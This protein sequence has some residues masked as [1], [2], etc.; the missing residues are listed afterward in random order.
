MLA[1]VV[2]EGGCTQLTE[3]PFV[4]ET[5]CLQRETIMIEL[6][7]GLPDNVLALRGIGEVTADDYKGVLV[8]AVEEKLD[9]HKKI[10]LLYVLGDDFKRYSAGAAWEDAKVGMKHFTSWD[11]VAVVTDVDWIE[12]AVK[13]VAFAMPCEVR[14]FDDDEL[15]EA[16]QWISEPLPTSNLSFEL[17]RDE[18]IL[19]LRPS[20]ELEAGDFEK[21]AATVDPY[22]EQ[23][24]RLNGLMIFAEKF[25]GWEDFGALVSHLRFVKDHQQKIGRIAMVS[26]D[27]VISMAPRLVRHFVSAEVRRYPVSEKDEALKWLARGGSA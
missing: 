20:G 26:D 5:L 7:E 4:W 27:K 9:K 23:S 22:I 6:L 3:P 14:L 10:R 2:P 12:H 25:P 24:G 1:D 16:R 21:I 8:P 19:V 15:D 17:L 18:A 11:R 13:A